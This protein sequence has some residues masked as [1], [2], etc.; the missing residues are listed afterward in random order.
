MGKTRQSLELTHLDGA[1][2]LTMPSLQ[3]AMSKV[4]L[5]YFAVKSSMNLTLFQCDITAQVDVVTQEAN[6]LFDEQGRPPKGGQK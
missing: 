2:F 4:D 1:S 3:E 5:P 6:V